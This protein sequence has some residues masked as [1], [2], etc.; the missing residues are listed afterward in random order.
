MKIMLHIL[1]FVFGFLIAGD[2]EFV[3][4]NKLESDSTYSKMDDKISM[5]IYDIW[6]EDDFSNINYIKCQYK[7]IDFSPL[8]IRGVQYIQP[9]WIHSSDP[10]NKF[11]PNES[12]YV[13]HI[14]NTVL[15]IQKSKNNEFV[16]DESSLK[17]FVY[18]DNLEET[19]KIKDNLILIV[20]ETNIPHNIDKTNR[21]KLKPITKNWMDTIKE[22][23]KALTFA[24]CFANGLLSYYYISNSNKNF[25]LYNVSS[26]NDVVD[27]YKVLS[28]RQM[29]FGLVFSVGTMWLFTW[30]LFM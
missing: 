27:D 22:N 18:K 23:K 21:I 16:L 9:Q 17:S 30:G 15:S 1:F 12:V 2:L 28:Q 13:Y 26:D 25:Y 19:K 7:D 24:G 20:D 3:T 6:K 14:F 5:L 29:K 10:V 4:D 11:I 8:K